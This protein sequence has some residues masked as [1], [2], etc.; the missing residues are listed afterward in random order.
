MS[1]EPR[2]EAGD[3][4]G[5]R[6]AADDGLRLLSLSMENI[7]PFDKAEIQFATGDDGAPP[8]TILTGENGTGKTIVLDAI[9]GMFGGTYARLERPI[10]RAGVSFRVALK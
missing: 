1:D 3:A 7:G 5:D 2:R 8:V 6:P 10:H 9:R 4:G